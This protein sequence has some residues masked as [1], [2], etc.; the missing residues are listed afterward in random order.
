MRASEHT[1]THTHTDMLEEVSVLGPGYDC[2][3]CHCHIN[4]KKNE[5]QNEKLKITHAIRT[6]NWV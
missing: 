4:I 6:R 5:T 2:F 1:H 3:L